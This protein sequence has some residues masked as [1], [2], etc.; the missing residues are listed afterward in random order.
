MMRVCTERLIIRP[1]QRADLDAMSIWRPQADP[2]LASC[3]PGQP[4]E[5]RDAWFTALASDLSRR[6]FAIAEISGQLVGRVSLREIDG[7]ACARLG[8][9]IGAEFAECGYGGEALEG[10]LGWCFGEGGFARM[11]LDVSA[12]NARAIRIYEKAGFRRASE[13]Y[14]LVGDEMVAPFLDDPRYADMRQYFKREDGQVWALFYE[15]ELTREAWQRMKAGV[16]NG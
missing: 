14:Q 4:G 1:L 5:E 6:D 2:I 3:S 12:A 11:V 9:V 16:R 15:M 10:F 13:R 8:I 7:Q